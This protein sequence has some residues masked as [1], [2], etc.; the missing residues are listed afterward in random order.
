MPKKIAHEGRR[1]GFTMVEA[2][3][4]LTIFGIGTIMLM[5]L[6]PRASQY[7]TRARVMSRANALAQAKVEEL[8]SLPKLHADLG[9]GTHDDP[10][11]PI[12]GAFTRSW[13]VIEDDP[14]DGM[15]KVE[16][17]VRVVTS[18][19]DSVTTLVTYF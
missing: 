13:D 8:R 7:A 15:R 3:V 17:Q 10:N 16:V 4:A 5:Q 2:L 6:A 19:S 12:E 18:S 11:N 14:I 1:A 9:A